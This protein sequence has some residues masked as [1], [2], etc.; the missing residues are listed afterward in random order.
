ML[1]ECHNENIPYDNGRIKAD[2]NE[3]SQVMNGTPLREMV[4]II[5][6]V[7]KLCRDHK[8]ADFIEGVKSGMQLSQEPK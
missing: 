3:R 8:R 7:C 2:F 4:K 1:Y 6:P 5:C